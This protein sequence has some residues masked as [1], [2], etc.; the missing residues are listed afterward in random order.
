LLGQ[1]C[2]VKILAL[3]VTFNPD[4]AQLANLIQAVYP[5]VAAVAVFDNASDKPVTIPSLD[6]LHLVRNP[7]N[8]GLASTYNQ[9]IDLARAMNATHLLIFDQDSC[10]ASD[11]V[12]QLLEVMTCPEV[13]ANGPVAAVGPMYQDVKGQYAPPFVAL[14]GLR[15]RRIPCAEGECVEVDHLISSGSLISMEALDQVGRFQDDLFID[16]VDTE[17]CWRARRKG[18]RLL[19][20]GA[21]KMQ[22]SLGEAQFVVLGRP[23]PLHSPFRLYYQMRNQWWMILQPGTGWRW[24]AMDVVRSMKIFLAFSIYAPNKKQNVLHMLRGIADAFRGRMG[25]LNSD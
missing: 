1:G 9:G 5:Q 4:I 12:A 11:M 7:T 18:F 24:R 8:V 16:Y 17:W 14:R 13:L 23:R 10:P 25:K 20:V 15:L 3:I 2:S 6:N 22:H 21:A 19:G